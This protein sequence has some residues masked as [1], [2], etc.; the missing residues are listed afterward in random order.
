MKISGRLC[1]V[2]RISLW[3]DSGV[4]VPQGL[5]VMH[6]CDNPPCVNPKHLR[7]GTKMDNSRD[8]VNK[9][10]NVFGERHSKSKLTES[11]VLNIRADN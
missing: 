5:V 11:Q 10:R 4:E 8:C 3:I 6:S 1:L 2:T 7:P 9:K